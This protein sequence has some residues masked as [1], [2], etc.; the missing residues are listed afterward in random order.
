[1]WVLTGAVL[2]ALLAGCAVTSPVSEE[3]YLQ[4]IA[5]NEVDLTMLPAGDYTGQYTIVVPPGHYAA[6]R[7]FTVQVTVAGGSYGAI[8][9]VKPAAM[10]A[11]GDFA[12]LI[13][14]IQAKNSLLVDGVSGA[15]YSSRAMLKAVEAAVTR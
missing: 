10:A 6:F 4:A 5:V 8:S 15:T 7:S 11:N 9:I 1:M 12:A 14:R 3:R 13:G 2:I